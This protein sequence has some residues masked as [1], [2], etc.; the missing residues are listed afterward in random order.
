M[1]VILLGL[2]TSRAFDLQLDVIFP[3]VAA[4][5]ASVLITFTPAASIAIEARTFARLFAVNFSLLALVALIGPG[6]HEINGLILKL[7][8]IPLSFLAMYLRR[9]GM[10]GQRSASPSSS[11]PPSPP[12]CGP[13]IRR[14]SGCCWRRWRA[15]SSPPSSASRRSGQRHAGL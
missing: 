1:V 5:T 14:G 2:A 10:D 13:P 8:L 7:L 15:A 11:W 12:S 3:M 4:M 6:D 9:Y